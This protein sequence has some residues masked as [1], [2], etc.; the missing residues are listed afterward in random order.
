M[1]V[2]KWEMG[3]EM[4]YKEALIIK[5]IRYAGR[6]FVYVCEKEYISLRCYKTVCYLS[7]AVDSHNG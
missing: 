2:G 6:L 7:A 1:K 4:G 3:T 5:D